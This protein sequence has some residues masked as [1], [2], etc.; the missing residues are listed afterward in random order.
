MEKFEN[1]A[2]VMVN[3]GMLLHILLSQ[4]NLY[5]SYLDIAVLF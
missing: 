1:V 4:I 5:S 3:S 2:K